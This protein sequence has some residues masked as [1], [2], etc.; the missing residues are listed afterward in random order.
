MARKN[1]QESLVAKAEALRAEELRQND[2]AGSYIAA[3]ERASAAS[4]TAQAHAEAV[5]QALDIITT[6]GVTL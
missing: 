4:I 6:A 2:A 1:L 3:A 5:E